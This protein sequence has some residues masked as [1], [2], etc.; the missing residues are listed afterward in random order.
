M[1]PVTG[2]LYLYCSVGYRVIALNIVYKFS[3]IS[4]TATFAQILFQYQVTCYQ[5][6]I[7]CHFLT[8]FILANFVDP[9]SLRDE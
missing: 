3:M 4:T 1:Q 5:Q 7:L 6:V 2:V 9:I 8:E